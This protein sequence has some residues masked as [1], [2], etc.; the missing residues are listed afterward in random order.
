MRR[1]INCCHDCFDRCVGCHATCEKYI[2]QK[3]EYDEYIKMRHDMLNEIHGTDSAIKKM[4]RHLN[5]RNG[6]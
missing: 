6:R 4:K 2:S 3:K 1:T 5:R